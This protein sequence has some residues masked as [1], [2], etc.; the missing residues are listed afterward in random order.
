MI[1]TRPRFP[2]AINSASDAAGSSNE[3]AKPRAHEI[4]EFGPTEL[5]TRGQPVKHWWKAGRLG[6]IAICSCNVEHFEVFC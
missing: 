2:A 4:R 3:A 1:H 6:R 5:S